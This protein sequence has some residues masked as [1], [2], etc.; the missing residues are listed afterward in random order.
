MLPHIGRPADSPTGTAFRPI[1]D[2]RTL[3]GWHAVPRLGFPPAI[4]AEK[5]PSGEL[6][7]RLHAW[8]GA[9]PKRQRVLDHR[10]HWE[11]VDGAIVGGQQ[12]PGS[13]LGAYLLT[14][15]TFGD[16]ELELEARPDW[17]ADTGIMLRAHELGNVGF[18]I[19]V[20]HRPNGAIGGVFG[21]KLGSF[22]AAP[23]S[24]TG[25]ELPGFRVGNL[26]EGGSESKFPCPKM[27]FAAPFSDFSKAWRVNDWNQFRVRCVGEV[28]TIT[29]WINGAKICELD[30]TTITAPGFS[31]A[32]V[33][34]LLGPA[35]RIGF[36][37]HDNDS[38]GH[39]RWAEGAVCRW[40][41]IQVRII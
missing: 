3:K 18:Q 8:Y 14:D 40:R 22:R 32:L 41:N 1:F 17:P 7:E 12:P 37:V 19:N 24:V 30:T 13:G 21:N 27:Q 23:F 9:D 20:D 31:P 5:I 34:R 11:V 33:K 15:D 4:D 39:N 16:F 26:R 35:G 10:G 25:D 28:P 38:M 29:T 2:G 36:E 6:R